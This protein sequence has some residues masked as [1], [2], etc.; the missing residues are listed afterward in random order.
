[1]CVN[2]SDVAGYM[3]I[4]VGILKICCSLT[5][6]SEESNKIMILITYRNIVTQMSADRK[7]VI[8]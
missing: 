2:V 5:P 6:V 8:R 7:L 4:L 3:F 1:M